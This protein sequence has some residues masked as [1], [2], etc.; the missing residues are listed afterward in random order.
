M[1]TLA[2]ATSEEL[3]AEVV[4]RRKT[5]IIAATATQKGG[6]AAYIDANCPKA[7]SASFLAGDED[8]DE[9]YVTIRTPDSLPSNWTLVRLAMQSDPALTVIGPG[10]PGGVADCLRVSKDRAEAVLDFIEANL[11]E[12]E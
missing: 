7:K 11:P 9:Q 6:V 5:D 2:Q 1:P 12:E 3:A 8:T 4:A 10:E